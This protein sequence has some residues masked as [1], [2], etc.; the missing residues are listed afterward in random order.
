MN[1]SPLRY[2]LH[3]YACP[4]ALL[5]SGSD[6]FSST[7]RTATELWHAWLMTLTAA[8]TCHSCPPK[9]SL[10]DTGL[11]YDHFVL[12]TL[13]KHCL[14]MSKLESTAVNES[15]MRA[16]V[17]AFLGLHWNLTKSHFERVVF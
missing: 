2:V 3:L 7:F 5:M 14:I 15:T 8:S 16:P 6:R 12:S 1:Y 4:D 17:D 9:V 11:V 13:F 10:F